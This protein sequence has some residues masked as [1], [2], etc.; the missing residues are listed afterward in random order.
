M[1]QISTHC[2][3][4]KQNVFYPHSEILFRREKKWSTDARYGVGEPG[5][6][7]MGWKKPG[8]KAIIWSPWDA[9][10]GTGKS[11]EIESG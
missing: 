9:V 7:Y 8:A 1:T 5:K 3:M 6:D 10:S 2:W 11:V 4:R